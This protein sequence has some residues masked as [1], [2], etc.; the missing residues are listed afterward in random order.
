MMALRSSVGML[1]LM[2][3]FVTLLAATGCQKQVEQKDEPAAGTKFVTLDVT[4]MT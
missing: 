1:V 4:G 2:L 3:A